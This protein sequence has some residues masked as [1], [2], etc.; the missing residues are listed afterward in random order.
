MCDERNYYLKANDAYPKRNDAIATQSVNATD[1]YEQSLHYLGWKFSGSQETLP[2]LQTSQR[3]HGRMLRFKT[4]ARRR[5][6]NMDISARMGSLLH[7]TPG[8]WPRAG[9][10]SEAR[11]R[12]FCHET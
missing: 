2:A 1:H 12:V 4:V 3:K 8:R 11:N 5:D 7:S 10:S 6:K 9:R